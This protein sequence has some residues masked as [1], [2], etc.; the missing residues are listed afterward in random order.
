MKKILCLLLSS[1]FIFSSISVEV[2]E[3]EI[4]TSGGSIEFINYSGTHTQ[5]DT[6]EQIRG[7]GTQLGGAATTGRAGEQGRYYV[8]HIVDPNDTKGFDADILIIG[9]RAAVDHI[10]NLRLI[11]AG[12]L[13]GAYGYSANDASTI[14][15]FVTIYN[16]VHRGDMAYF[17]SKYK[18]AVTTNLT[19]DKVGLSTR[20]DEWP[21][22]TQIVIPLSDPRFAGTISSVDT[23]T[24]TDKDVIDKVKQEDDKDIDAREQM[25]DLKERESDEAAKRA[26][27]AQKEA[28]QKQKEAEQKQKEA[29]QKQKEADAAQKAGDTETAEQKQKEADAAKAEAD[30]AKAEADKKKD[31]AAAEQKL[32]DKKD[33]EAQDERKDVAADTQKIIE[34]K[35]DEKKAASDAAI[36]S[37]VPGY[38]LKVVD[39]SKLLSELVL[40]DL[41]TAKELKTSAVKTIHGRCLLDSKGRLMAIAGTTEG[42][43]VITLVLFDPKS[44]EVIKQ[45]DDNIASESVLVQNESDYY[46]V[47]DEGGKY[48]IGRFDGE[49]KLQAKSSLQVLPYSPITIV[50]EGIMVQATDNTLRLIGL[51][52]L[53]NVVE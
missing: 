25:I 52:D 22:K 17:T 21:G 27:E 8:M 14:A 44:L 47:I 26:E 19:S 11:L 13:Q 9:E 51:K 29:E 31:D 1:I 39:T 23:T 40:L 37:S 15:H 35:A 42:G 48:Y 28:A 5:I 53:I 16:A 12:Y 33:K 20:Y 6:I 46:A 43:S 36:A 38:G 45:G 50:D 2:D 4:R 10:N 7:I 24:I 32:S 3:D 41:K 49:L 30:A 34:E 18:T